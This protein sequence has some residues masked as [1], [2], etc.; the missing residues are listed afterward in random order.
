[1]KHKAFGPANSDPN[2]YR[3]QKYSSST[4]SIGNTLP[5]PSYQKYSSSPFL[6]E[7]LF[8]SLCF[9]LHMLYL[10]LSLPSP[11]APSL[12]LPTST[13]S[14]RCMPSS[15]ALNFLGLLSPSVTSHSYLPSPAPSLLT[16]YFSLLSPFSCPLPPH[17]HE[18]HLPTGELGHLRVHIPE[19]SGHKPNHYHRTREVRICVIYISSA[20]VLL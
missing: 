15:S 16:S 4:S 14:R 13:P 1:M 9:S 7:M 5:V 19:I 11:C 18:T 10:S 2:R 12:S 3:N 6:S 8:L 20:I 17:Q